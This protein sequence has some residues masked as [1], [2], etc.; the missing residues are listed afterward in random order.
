MT[1]LYPDEEGY[2]SDGVVIGFCKAAGSIA[3]HSAVYIGNTAVSGVVSVVAGSADADSCGVALKAA[4]T[5][6]YIPVAFGGIVKFVA[7]AAIAEG[8]M[9]ENDASATYAIPISTLTAGQLVLYRGLN[10]TGTRIRLGMA[11]Q[12]GASS[13]DEFLL[14]IGR[15]I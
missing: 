3:L 12:A 9:V 7:G 2:I 1:D 4:D 6:D 8:D 10:Y 15:V 14:L 11:L 13:G 5:N